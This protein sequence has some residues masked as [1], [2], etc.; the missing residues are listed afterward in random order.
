MVYTG[1]DGDS[2]EKILGAKVVKKLS[3][4]LVGGITYYIMIIISLYLVLDLLEDYICAYGMFQ[5]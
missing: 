4:E 2:T 1:K 5:W 3:R